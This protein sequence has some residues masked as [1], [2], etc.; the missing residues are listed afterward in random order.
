MRTSSTS[1]P[2]ASPVLS[3]QVVAAGLLVAGAI[4]LI[5][6]PEH[7]REA[8]VLGAGFLAVAVAQGVLGGLFLRRPAHA[9]WPAVLVLS[10]FSLTAYLLVHLFGVSVMPD[11]DAE[12]I[13]VLDLLCK[14]A[15]V[16]TAVV[17]FLG[18]IWLPGERMPS[19]F[20]W[21]SFGRYTYPVALIVLGILCALVAL[22]L[23]S[24]IALAEHADAVLKRLVSSTMNNHLVHLS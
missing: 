3:R 17:A 11:Q 22:R 19:R 15:E 12:G 5:L 24:H 1:T 10:V 23:G 4:H 14:G 16:V 7:L 2:S 8:P 6:A 9:L 13:G 20:R 21:L 18:L